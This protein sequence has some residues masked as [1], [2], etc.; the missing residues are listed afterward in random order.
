MAKQD[1]EEFLSQIQENNAQDVM[2]EMLRLMMQTVLEEGIT[3]HVGAHSHERTDTRTGHRNGYKP[4]RL[5][6]RMG[7]LALSVPQARGIEPYEPFPL[8]KY[9]RS[10]RALLVACAEMYFMGVSTRKVGRVLEEM[11]GFNLSATTV[12]RVA[13]ELDERLTEF[14]NRR[15]EAM[16]WP[17]LMVDACYVK[18]RKNGRVVSQAVLVVA[19]INDDGRREILTWLVDDVESEETWSE[20]FRDLRHRGVQGVKWV[21]SDGHEGIQAAV[22][23]QFTGASWQRCWT[24]FMRSALAK[25]SHKDQAALAKELCGAR[26]LDDPKLCLAEAERIALRWEKRYPRLAVQIRAQFEETL[27]VHAL[28]RE[29]RR[30]VYTTNMLERLMREIKRRTRVVGIFPNNASC[31]RLIG[32]Q[33]LEIH[34]NWQCERARYITFEHPTALPISKSGKQKAA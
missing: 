5:K 34:E 10:E 16:A 22:T 1:C 14:R 24:H 26:K 21:V 25:V 7:E 4:R 27:A 28:P 13:G 2:L 15:L 30:R 18:A 32:V 23:K 12:S 11:G 19:G 8:A 29:Q 3:R 9:Q 17:F 6:T 33:L 20:V 31:D